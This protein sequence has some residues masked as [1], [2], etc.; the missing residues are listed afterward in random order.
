[1]KAIH[2]I[3]FEIKNASSSSK[4]RVLLVVVRIAVIQRISGEITI[5]LI[6]KYIQLNE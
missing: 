2:L 5:I 4:L 1:M 3:P 6:I